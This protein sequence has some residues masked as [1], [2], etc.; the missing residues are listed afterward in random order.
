MEDQTQ[1]GQSADHLTIV[2]ATAEPMTA[3]NMVMV[4]A[5]NSIKE[6]WW[7]SVT[8]L[9][10]G[11]AQNLLLESPELQEDVRMLEGLGI[12]VKACQSC[13]NNMGITEELRALGLTVERVGAELTRN[14]K[15]AGSVITV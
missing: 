4:Y 11:G 12:T 13:S 1:A 15:G 9:I 5:S 3:K 10:W 8:V 7:E 14:L 2:W 6:G